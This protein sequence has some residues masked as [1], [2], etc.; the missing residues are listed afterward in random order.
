MTR[1]A[2][3]TVLALA[4]ASTLPA[5]DWPQW[6]GPKRDGGTPEAVEPWADAPKELW[7]AKAGAGFSSPV[8]AGGKV[9][10]H[11]RV[12]LKEREEM[13]ALDAGS[14]KELWRTAYD[15]GPYF[16]VLNTGPRATRRSPGAGCTGSGSPASCP[17]SRPTPASWSGRWTPSRS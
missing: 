4:L 15:R 5:A 7:R 10:V 11:A 9:L 1:F 8:V 2:S 13:I 16:S 6:L 12:P 14:G 17:A 3:A